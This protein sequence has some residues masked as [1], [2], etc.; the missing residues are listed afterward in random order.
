MSLPNNA[1]G[2]G[3]ERTKMECIRCGCFSSAR[4]CWHCSQ[5]PDA[6]DHALL[7]GY[8]KDAERYRWLRSKAYV[9]SVI[10][11]KGA[12][13]FWTT[14]MSLDCQNGE[15]FDESVDAAMR[16]VIETVH[17]TKEK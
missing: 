12:E 5:R 9:A 7:D 6:I 8:R 2:Q 3:N 10:G 11:A 1:I 16:A 14:V 13:N 15:S 4:I 17:S